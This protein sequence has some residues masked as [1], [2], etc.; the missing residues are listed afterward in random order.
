MNKKINSGWKVLSV[1]LKII[2]F[3][4]MC[5]I[6]LIACVIPLT[7]ADKTYKCEDDIGL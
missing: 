6:G 3:I 2:L 4:P 7:R 5:V 1:A